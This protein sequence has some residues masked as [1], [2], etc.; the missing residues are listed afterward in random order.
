MDTSAR[1]ASETTV[2][3][4]ARRYVELVVATAGVLL[5]FVV[6]LLIGAAVVGPHDHGLPAETAA[7][8]GDTWPGKPDN[9]VT[10]QLVPNCYREPVVTDAIVKQPL[11][12]YSA[13]ALTLAGLWVLWVLGRERAEGTTG[14]NPMIGNGFYLGALGLV[15]VL[16]GPGA[17][18]FHTPLTSWGGVLDQ[19]SMYLLLGFMVAYNVVRTTRPDADRA[20]F[21]GVFAA[22]VVAGFLVAAASGDISTYLFIASALLVALFEVLTF[23]VFLPRR[24]VVR[25]PG[26]FWFGAVG[27]LLAGVG[28][29][30]AGNPA[31]GGPTD[32]PFH[33]LWHVAA[34]VFLVAYFYYLRSETAKARVES[35]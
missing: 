1:T 23:A 19:V 16:M 14:S 35:T 17:I 29:W 30:I 6:L 26:R 21:V 31:V 33:L 5:F 22:V 20:V 27:A 28:V 11:S 2:G 9:C 13:F 10:G 25:S 8:M 18:L 3:T 34:G 24:N 12:T 32:F 7:I 15:G 4:L